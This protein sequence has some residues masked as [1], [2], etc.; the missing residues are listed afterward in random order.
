[1]A[2]AVVTDSTSDLPHE[3][4]REKAITVVPLTV[5]FG[6]E[7]FRDGLD[8]DADRFYERLQGGDVFPT[9]SQPSVGSFAQTYRE[10]AGS[11]DGI[12]SLHLS[13]KVSGTYRSAMQARAEVADLGCPIEVIDT[14][15]ASMSLGLVASAVA[16]VVRDGVGFEEAAGIARSLAERAYLYGMVETLEYLR[17]GGRVGRAQ[18]FLGSLLRVRPILSFVDGVVLGVERPRTRSKGIR[19]LVEMA[20][21]KAPLDSLCVLDSTD[22]AG[23]A[24]LASRVAHLAPDGKPI[25]ARFGP[26]VGAYLGP[27]ALGVTLISRN[28]S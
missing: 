11:C 20:E 19:R 16:D 14:L 23:A 15:Q 6:D 4:A 10:L 2:I 22:S 25:M 7:T 18:F 17:R 24:E 3:L 21:E 8:I 28:R 27:G 5:A 13:T 1:M 12:I 26:I 9:T